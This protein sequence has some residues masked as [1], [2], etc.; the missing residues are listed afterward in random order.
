LYIFDV[1]AVFRVIQSADIMLL[2]QVLCTFFTQMLSLTVYLPEFLTFLTVI[3]IVASVV[4][5]VGTKSDARSCRIRLP[6]GPW[7]QLPVLGYLPWLGSK[8]YITMLNLAKDYGPIY[9][10]PLGRRR[11]VILN[12]TETIKTALLRHAEQLSGRPD[13]PSFRTFV[14]NNSI[15]FSTSSP[16]WN[17][18]RKAAVRVIGAFVNNDKYPIESV[19]YKHAATLADVLHHI[20]TKHKHVDPFE[21]V[22]HATVDVLY[23][24]CF[25]STGDTGDELGKELLKTL[26][27]TRNSLLKVQVADLLPWTACFFRHH[28]ELFERCMNN[29]NRLISA[30]IAQVAADRTSH[31]CSNPE[32]IAEAL[33]DVSHDLKQ[34][35]QLDDVR[36]TT[37]QLL[38]TI[39]DLI[40]AGSETVVSYVHWAIL[41][42]A[43]YPDVQRRLRHEVLLTIG[44]TRS[45]SSADRPALPFTESF[46]WEVLR[47]AC[48]V[49]IAIPHSATSD[50]IIE[51]YFVPK[52]TIV[53]ANLYS[54]AWDP[55]FWGDPHEFRPERW[56]SDPGDKINRYLVDQFLCFGVGRRKCLGAQLARIE[57]FIFTAVLIQKCK[58][59]PVPGLKLTLDSEFIQG[60]RAKPY[61]VVISKFNEK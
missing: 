37:E 42:M 59:D 26:H 6:P 7:C 28:F 57:M 54:T 15:T 19:I 41:Y 17:I 25:G 4:P 51:G 11:A 58:F 40:G 60:N 5:R 52:D 45:P 1:C 31:G 46:M 61:H 14:S 24:L 9:Q 29:F 23:Q 27:I 56:L 48:V 39:Q 32:S 2:E 8:P 50:V 35:G 55:A 10:L 44:D 53:L 30:K 22:E 3:L 21:A 18:H 33:L 34:Q 20:S 38:M 47:H 13:F 12:G 16:S 49:P 43:K 36:V